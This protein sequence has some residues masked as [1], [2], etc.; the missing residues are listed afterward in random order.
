MGHYENNAKNIF[1][2]YNSFFVVDAEKNVLWQTY[3][4]SFPPEY[5]QIHR[6]RRERD[7]SCCRSFIKNF[8][9]VVVVEDNKIVSFWDFRTG[10]EGYDQVL[11]AM[12]NLV[13]SK[14]IRDVFITKNSSIGTLKNNEYVDGNV[15][16]WSHLFVSFPKNVV[17]T[18]YNS[19]NEI[20]GKYRDIKNV[21]HRS[22]EELSMDSVKEVLDLI[23]E[24][25]L[26][27]GEEWSATLEKFLK[28]QKE[29]KKLKTNAEKENFVWIKSIEAGAVVGKIRN[30]SIGT[31][32]IDISAGTDTEEAIRKYESI[33][34][35]TNY[36]RPK[37][38]ITSKMIDSARK[39]IE[40]LGLLDSLG[41][42]HSTISDITINN[43]L[44]A[45]RNA[46]KSMKDGSSIFQEMKN[47]V[48]INPKNFEKIKGIS[49]ESFLEKLP[50]I[51]DIEILLENRS[52]G[53]LFSL[54]SPIN[55]DAP[56][57]FKWDNAFSWSYNGNLA[58][59]MKE[60]VKSAGGKIDG[61]LRFSIQW[62]TEN[63]NKNDFDAHCV[64][65]NGNEIFYQNK[66]HV[67]PSSGVLDVD[68]I[69]PTNR[70]AVENIT[71]SDTR[72]MK[73]GK[74]VFFVHNFSHNGGTS[75]F[76][77][78]IEFNGEVYEFSYH[79][80]IRYKDSVYVA[81][82][83]LDNEK[84]FS[85]KPLLEHSTSNR[86]VWNISTN[87]FS[88]VSVF[89]FSPNYWDEQKGNGNRHY[90]FVLSNCVNDGNPNGFYNEYLKEDLLKHKKMFEVLGSKMKVENSEQQ[91][92][93]VGF[94]STKKD[95]LIAKID[96]NITK[97]IF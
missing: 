88:P 22:L 80:D 51:K 43:V 91:L 40:S 19:I 20:M 92:S 13:K 12:E 97:I 41:R 75:G 59:S 67:H 90:F 76:D 2:K 69:H 15:I 47:E 33:V 49:I 39:T 53:N 14:P 82:V 3:L 10:D 38:I 79:K 65:P 45:N 4:E 34:A 5:N 52:I 56:S 78:E 85:I 54:I 68:I 61:V 23:S 77:A 64:E 7:C 58:D 81:E 86:T 18:G 28:Y 96:G 83:Y 60:R 93:G 46:K 29:Y 6:T 87:V 8:A 94:S 11:E 48:G 16:I 25:S 95:Y 55:K 84:N 17:D 27:R 72:K 37:A 70:P 21:F 32:L 24:K 30:H 9:N 50:E 42:R 62:N 26:Y 31:L 66:T 1:K 35:P 74:Y 73:P 36:K 44:W 63:D 89:M 57:M 71:W